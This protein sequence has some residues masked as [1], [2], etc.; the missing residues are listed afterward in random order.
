MLNNYSFAK[1]RP[2]NHEYIREVLD[3]WLVFV[4]ADLA[5]PWADGKKRV[6]RE[7][8]RQKAESGE[9]N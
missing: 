4:L 2:D 5:C 8:L 3:G 7:G 1:S 9:D 6:Q